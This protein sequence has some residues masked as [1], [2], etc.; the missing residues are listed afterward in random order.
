MRGL[1][2]AN[3][4]HLV[5]AA[6][7]VAVESFQMEDVWKAV[8]SKLDKT[9]AFKQHNLPSGMWFFGDMHL[10]HGFTECDSVNCESG[11][12]LADPVV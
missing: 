3:D 6:I 4:Y 9:A 10:L 12:V 1:P 8:D 2:A 11:Q 7:D 5:T